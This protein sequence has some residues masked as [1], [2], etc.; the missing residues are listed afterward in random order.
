MQS[1]WKIKNHMWWWHFVDE[2]QSGGR[3]ENSNKQRWA[4]VI[5]ARLLGCST[6]CSNHTYRHSEAFFICSLRCQ[7]KQTAP[8][9]ALFYYCC[10]ILGVV[11]S[12][13]ALKKKWGAAAW[14]TLFIYVQK[15]L[16]TFLLSFFAQKPWSN[17][18]WF[19]VP[20]PAHKD[21]K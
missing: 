19:R 2:Y 8:I 5:T 21:N 15:D 14:K 12:R 4:T 17:L 11:E 3:N 18:N 1:Y 16:I 20:P 13:G 9:S 10:F 7:N 6:I